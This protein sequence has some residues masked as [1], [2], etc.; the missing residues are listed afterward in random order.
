M[1]IVESASAGVG[2]ASSPTARPAAEV[3]CNCL[4]AKSDMACRYIS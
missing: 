1:R 3:C 4:E 2:A